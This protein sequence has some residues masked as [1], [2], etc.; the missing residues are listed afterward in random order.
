[1][2]NQIIIWLFVTIINI[3]L[4]TQNKGD[5]IRVMKNE[6]VIDSVPNKWT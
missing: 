5:R 3:S 4:F 6:I 2:K 1:M